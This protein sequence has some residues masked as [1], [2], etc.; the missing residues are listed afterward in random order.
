MENNLYETI[1]QIAKLALA[2]NKEHTFGTLATILNTIAGSPQNKGGRGTARK[3]T[4]AY[5]YAARNGRQS[6]AD[7]VA[8]AFCKK[9]G[10]KAY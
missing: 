5:Q 10:T 9:D 8:A 4:G 6:D 3:V 2:N 7:A 1:I